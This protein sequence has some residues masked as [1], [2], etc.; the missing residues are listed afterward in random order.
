MHEALADDRIIGSPYQQS[1]TIQMNSADVILCVHLPAVQITRDS[2]R[3][4]SRLK[5][6]G[7]NLYGV[8]GFCECCQG[9]VET[10]ARNNCKGT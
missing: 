3:I 1:V 10:N 4:Y 7:P 6:H 5:P 8:V 2:V 9:G